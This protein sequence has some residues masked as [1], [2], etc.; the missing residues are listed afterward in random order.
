M[1]WFVSNVDLNSFLAGA[2]IAMLPL[3]V[4]A[5]MSNLESV[6]ADI[7][8]LPVDEIERRFEAGYYPTVN[9]VDG[10]NWLNRHGEIWEEVAR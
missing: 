6:S 10:V 3:A 5:I 7:V 8:S 1:D 4:I 9:K 2:C